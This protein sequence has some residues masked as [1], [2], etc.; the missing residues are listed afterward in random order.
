MYY[1]VMIHL[2]VYMVHG[3]KTPLYVYILCG[4]HGSRCIFPFEEFLTLEHKWQLYF[5]VK[6]DEAKTRGRVHRL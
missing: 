3:S 4:E 5:E 1:Y 2:F 6:E